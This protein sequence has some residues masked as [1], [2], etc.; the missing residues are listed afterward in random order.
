[1][2]SLLDDT[3]GSVPRS[4]SDW[5]YCLFFPSTLEEFWAVKSEA[6]LPLS[7]VYIPLYT[8]IHTYNIYKQSHLIH[9]L[10]ERKPQ[11][12]SVIPYHTAGFFS[13]LGYFED[14]GETQVL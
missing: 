11:K 10:C 1:M 9:S 12:G 14:R 2:F 13:G 7:H 8:H 6:V 5:E 4:N 3:L